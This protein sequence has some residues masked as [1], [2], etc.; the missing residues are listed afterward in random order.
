MREQKKFGE[1]SASQTKVR[2]SKYIL[3][4]EGEK[5]E[6]LYFEAINNNKEKIGISSLIQLVPM[7]RTIS[8]EHWSNPLKLLEEFLRKKSESTKHITYKTF[9]DCI[10][11]T[12]YTDDSFNSVNSG[13][14][15]VVYSD[16]MRFYPKN[17]LN[18]YIKDIDQEI[19]NVVQHFKIWSTFTKIIESYIHQK[20]EEQMLNLEDEDKICLVVDRDFDSFTQFK[21]V[22]SICNGNNVKFYITNPRFE[23]FLLLHSP[24]IDFLDNDK[25]FKDENNYLHSELKKLLGAYSKEKFNTEYFINHIQ[26][27][28]KNER[29]YCENIEQLENTLGS[30]VGLL[31]QELLDTK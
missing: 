17:T 3:I 20:I 7:V 19:E 10:I 13:F 18:E 15:K 28:I 14:D 30:N 29:K 21:E 27:A 6:P 9:I 8:E 5:T 26:D 24:N 25:L 16:L 23:F 12:I 31:L 2:L 22:V 1:R 4:M 11:D